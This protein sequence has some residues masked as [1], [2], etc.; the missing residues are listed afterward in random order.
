MWGLLFQ[1]LHLTDAQIEQVTDLLAQREDNDITVAAAA[2]T[3]GVDKSSPQIQALDDQL[4]EANKAAL[5]AAVGKED[6][7]ASHQ[8]LHEQEIIPL[9]EELAR[10]CF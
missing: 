1:S 10:K 6:Y 4:D 7:A 8:Y 5:K 3:Q 9:V 2:L